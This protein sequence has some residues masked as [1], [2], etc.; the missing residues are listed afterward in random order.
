MQRLADAIATAGVRRLLLMV[1]GAGD[2]TRTLANIAR[3][4]T[5][6]LPPLREVGGPVA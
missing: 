6:V 4:G 2:A 1:A 5:E 3:L